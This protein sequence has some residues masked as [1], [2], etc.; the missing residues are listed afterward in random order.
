MKIKGF[1]N[2]LFV[3]LNKTD[4]RFLLLAT[5]IDPRYKNNSNL[6]DYAE[7]IQNVGLLQ[8]ELEIYLIPERRN[9]IS[10]SPPREQS[11]SKNPME[12]FL[13]PVEE[14]NHFPEQAQI[15]DEIEAFFKVSISRI[16]WS[17]L[18]LL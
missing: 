1:D 6:F 3:F 17:N 13:D 15:S 12:A 7:R 16:L 14:V 5:L 4:I 8:S 9:S 10:I 18:I 11:A 2:N